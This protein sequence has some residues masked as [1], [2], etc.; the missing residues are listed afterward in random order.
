MFSV[1]QCFS[2]SGWAGYWT[3][4]WLS[5]KESII[6]FRRHGLIPGLGRSPGGGHGNLLQYSCL[7]TPMDRGAWQAT[8]YGVTKSQTGLS[9][10]AHAWGWLFL[11]FSWT[12]VQQGHTNSRSD[13]AICTCPWLDLLASLSSWCPGNLLKLLGNWNKI[14]HVKLNKLC[15]TVQTDSKIKWMHLITIVVFWIVSCN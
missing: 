13:S 2:E 6:Q 5:Y 15:A 3:S 8:V 9:D 1:Q 4:W 12:H 11:G 10:W 14:M 7:E